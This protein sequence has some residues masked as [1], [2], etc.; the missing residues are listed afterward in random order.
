MYSEF[1]YFADTASRGPLMFMTEADTG[2]DRV[3]T[4]RGSGVFTGRPGFGAYPEP[5]Y[6]SKP[7][8]PGSGLTTV[9]CVLVRLLGR[10]RVCIE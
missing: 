8:R 3:Y 9:R 1:R 2:G 4:T 5:G 7:G 10:V 6:T